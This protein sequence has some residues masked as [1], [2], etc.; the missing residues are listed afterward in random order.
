[1]AQD[2]RA[3]GECKSIIVYRV[4]TLYPMTRIFLLQLEVKCQ[5]FAACAETHAPNTLAREL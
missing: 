3:I 4:A 2:K 5:N 1:M